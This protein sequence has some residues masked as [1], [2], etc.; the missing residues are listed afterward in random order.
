[1]TP[2]WISRASATQRAGR[3]GR[4]RPGTVYRMYTK[5]NF[6]N[7]MLDFEPGEILRTPLDSVILMLKEMLSDEHVTDVL[8]SCIEPP[9]TT[10]IEASFNSLY[11]LHFITTPDDNG[12]ISELG[13]FACALGVDLA[14]CSLIGLG[15]QFGV[16]AE[17]IQMAAVLSF[18]QTPWI[19]S[20]PLV[21][22]PKSFNGKW[23]FTR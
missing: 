18:P 21:H 14:L 17:A 1:M 2:A 13:R 5:D 19:M 23:K 22:G 12:A 6:H 9:D 11:E 15:I 10:A 4:L 16:G 7:H 20:N 3:T 8:S